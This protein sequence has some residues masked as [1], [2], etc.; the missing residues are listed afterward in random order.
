LK[1]SLL[2]LLEPLYLTE[3]APKKNQR[4]NFA[5]ASLPLS[6]STAADFDIDFAVASLVFRFEIIVDSVHCE[7]S[8]AIQSMSKDWMLRQLRLLAMTVSNSGQE[9]KPVRPLD[10][11]RLDG[12]KNSAPLALAAAVRCFCSPPAKQN[13]F[14]PPPPPKVE[15]AVPVQKSITRY[16]MPPAIPGD[17]ERR[18]GRAAAGVFAI[19]QLPG[20]VFR[21]E[22]TPL[23][24][25]EPETYSSS[26]EQAQGR[27]ERRAGLAENRPRPISSGS[28]IVQR[29]AVSQAT[30]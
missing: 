14:V 28:R 9:M 30:L 18:P 5:A 15:V 22:G 2:F 19:D 24:T 25:I 29:Q 8:E 6:G 10:F 7:R 27:R 13:T 4:H 11:V 20:R 3:A 16:P 12:L 26:F 21:K 23:F 17:Q 1:K